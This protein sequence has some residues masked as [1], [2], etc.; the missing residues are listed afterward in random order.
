[1]HLRLRD[2]KWNANQLVKNDGDPQGSIGVGE[3]RAGRFASGR[4]FLATV[5]PMHGNTLAVYTLQG[6]SGGRPDRKVLTDQLNE[7][8]A[9]ATGDVLGD[10]A[11]EIV[12]GFRANPA[13]PQ[14]IGIHLWT[15]P[16]EEGGEWRQSVIDGESMACEDLVLADLDADGDLDIVA[17]GRATKNINVYWNDTP[18]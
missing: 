1:M 5:E 11:T 14:P 9:L 7:G 17:A 3:L 18:K 16:A 4:E 2:G 8:H 12:V 6:V 15:P 13:K 10:K